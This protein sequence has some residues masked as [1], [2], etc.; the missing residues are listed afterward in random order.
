MIHGF[1]CGEGE[2]VFF[3]GRIGNS[4]LLGNGCTSVVV[5][6]DSGFLPPTI[7]LD[8]TIGKRSSRSNI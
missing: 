7:D 5:A 3:C 2:E 8:G 6:G 1:V 4:L